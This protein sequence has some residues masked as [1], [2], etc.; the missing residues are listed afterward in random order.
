VVV[1]AKTVWGA[2]WP[3]AERLFLLLIFTDT[4]HLVPYQLFR[5]MRQPGSPDLSQGRCGRYLIMPRIV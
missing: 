2:A 4:V 3:E 5:L 1:I